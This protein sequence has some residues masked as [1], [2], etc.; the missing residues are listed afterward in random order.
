VDATY[1]PV[2]VDGKDRDEVII[3][4]Y[5]L[6]RDDL[7]AMLPNRAIPIALVKENVCRLGR[8]GDPVQLFKRS[9]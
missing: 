8:D 7:A 4:D 2:N 6:L 3:R 1:E 5:P 9:R